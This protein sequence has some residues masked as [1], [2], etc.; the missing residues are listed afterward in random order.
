M[1]QYSTCPH[2]TVLVQPTRYIPPWPRPP[3]LPGSRS[4]Q[5]YPAYRS[6][7]DTLIHTSTHHPHPTNQLLPSHASLHPNH[8][9]IPTPLSRKTPQ[10][11]NSTV[12]PLPISLDSNLTSSSPTP[13]SR[14]TAT[15]NPRRPLCSETQV[16]TQARDVQ[17]DS[18]PTSLHVYLNLVPCR[19]G[20][21]PVSS[22]ERDLFRVN[23]A[24]GFQIPDL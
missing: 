18:T 20:T 6:Q 3:N 21:A 7:L 5:R 12:P 1:R 16:A 24:H 23:R 19:V 4:A 10:R 13:P 22:I 15:C 11:H 2:I 9:R 8:P 14:R 17:S